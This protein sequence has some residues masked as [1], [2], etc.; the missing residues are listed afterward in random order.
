[1]E[2]YL[3]DSCGH[4]IPLGNQAIHSARCVRSSS[5]NRDEIDLST[6]NEATIPASAP[7]LPPLEANGNAPSGSGSTWNCPLCTYTN[8]GYVTSCEVCHSTVDGEEAVTDDVGIAHALPMD[9]PFFPSHETPPV[10]DDTGTQ[11]NTRQSTEWRCGACTFENSATQDECTMCGNMRPPQSSYRE[12]LVS[13]FPDA[14]APFP[15]VPREA[16]WM[17]GTGNPDPRQ[18]VM[19]QRVSRGDDVAGSMLLG[20][21]LGAGL[22][23]LNDSS[24]T[25]G[26]LAGAGLG[27]IGN[28]LMRDFSE[29]SRVSAQRQS[30]YETGAQSQPGMGE[31]RRQP[32]TVEQAMHEMMQQMMMG[33]RGGVQARLRRRPGG[34]G[35]MDVDRMPYAELLERFPQ[36]NRGLDAGTLDA[37]PV[38]SYA[39]PTSSS[40]AS[41]SNSASGSGK[42]P[43][44]GEAA[45]GTAAGAGG[46]SDSAGPA[47]SCTICLEDYRAGEPVKTLPCLHC[48][49]AECIDSWLRQQRTCPVCK[50][51]IE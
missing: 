1:M 40:A 46:S 2:T 24:I 7:P 18:P 51:T 16:Q 8:P 37:L 35:W 25:S 44:E 42:R 27:A 23:L 19:Q 10:A 29:Q 41:N 22:A 9:E 4:H 11:C 14:M 20:A 31:R 6:D 5:R 21:G 47:T 12:T 26:A 17:H 15:H 28:L 49:H 34:V 13:D 3:C 50:Y 30:Q 32:M 38:R 43:R 45:G 39:P 36:P 48:F 33:Q